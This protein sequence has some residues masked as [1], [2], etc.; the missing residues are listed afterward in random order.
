M[1]FSKVQLKLVFDKSRF[2]I[3]CNVVF[4]VTIIKNMT[5]R[6]LIPYIS[7]SVEPFIRL[8]SRKSHRKRQKTHPKN[9]I[10]LLHSWVKTTFLLGQLRIRPLTI[11]PN[12]PKNFPVNKRTTH[13]N[14]QTMLLA[15][16][17]VS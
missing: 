9:I 1:I 5:V 14:G 8:D 16:F 13:R 17:Y 12:A 4:R 6:K 11:G 15:P 10:F 7:K 3:F 2:L